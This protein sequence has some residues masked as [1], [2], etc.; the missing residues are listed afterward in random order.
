VKKY[1]FETL[2][3]EGNPTVVKPSL[4]LWYLLYVKNPLVDNAKFLRKF[5]RCFRLP[6][7]KF[8]ELVNIAKEAADDDGN[9]YF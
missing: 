4:T 1:N 8:L 2:D 6:H 3:E 7:N 9:L 5:C